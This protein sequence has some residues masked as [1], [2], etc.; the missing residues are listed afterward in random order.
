MLIQQI[1]HK[2][3]NRFYPAKLLLFGE[4]LLLL[5]APAL[6]VPAPLFGGRWVISSEEDEHT[7]H[8]RAFAACDAM[9][10]IP[11]LK[12]SYLMETIEG[13]LKFESNIPHGYGLGSS[14]ALCAGIYDRFCANP[15][16]EPAILKQLF[17]KMES[18]FHGSSSGID[19]L[20]S[21]LN[22]PLYIQEKTKVAV[23]PDALWPDG[24][25]VFLM[26]SHLPRQTGPLV[27][28]FLA[29]QSDPGFAA[30][31]DEKILPAHARTLDAWLAKEESVFWDALDQLSRLQWTH[32][33]PMI[34]DTLRAFWLE[35][36]EQEDFRLKICGAGGG[37]FVLGFAKNEDVV[38][39]LQQ[40]FDVILPF[41]TSTENG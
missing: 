40:K 31:M 13:G 24:P 7:H 23:K 11:D 26:D 6:A 14:G 21:Y 36:F 39:V 41:Q 17:A 16:T 3:G 8:L 5:G 25:V 28:W 32:F 27:Q 33:P 9:G 12:Q 35:S 38:K 29:Q 19:P 1:D 34:P 4:H 10:G 20:T 2:S 30:L 22:T 18:H 37:G 15:S